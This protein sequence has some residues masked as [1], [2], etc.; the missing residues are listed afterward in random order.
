MFRFLVY[1]VN[2][3]SCNRLKMCAKFVEVSFS[4]SQ[5]LLKTVIASRNVSNF[6]FRFL[7]CSVSRASC[8]RLKMYAKLVEAPFFLSKLST[9]KV[10]CFPFNGSFSLIFV[11]IQFR[12]QFPFPVFQTSFF[13]Q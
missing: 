10:F 12:N 8:Y 13:F 6:T 4:S 1:S 11:L 3:T 2:R 5:R 7:V 9:L